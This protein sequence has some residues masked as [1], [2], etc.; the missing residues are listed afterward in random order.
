MAIDQD[1]IMLL[2][3]PLTEKENPQNICIVRAI[4]KNQR[5][6][7][8]DRCVSVH[9]CLCMETSGRRGIRLHSGHH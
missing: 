9:L 5:N 7:S 8:M 3:V 4:G 2:M 6:E 1:P